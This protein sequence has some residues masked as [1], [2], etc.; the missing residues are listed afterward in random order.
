MVLVVAGA[1]LVALAILI[2]VSPPVLIYDERYYMESS[3][4]LAAHFDLLG[5]LRNPLDLA[6]GPL[7]PYVHALLAPLT[8]LQLPAVRYVNWVALAVE[9]LER[10]TV[11]VMK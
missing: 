4:T 7:Y 11:L 2:A 6:A 3:Y 1:V 5:P 9:R 8:K 10:V